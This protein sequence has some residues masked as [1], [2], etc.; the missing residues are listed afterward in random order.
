MSFDE[1]AYRKHTFLKLL[2][3]HPVL[4]QLHMSV[5]VEL[6]YFVTTALYSTV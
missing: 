4:E 2:N 6:P 1:Q 5:H 3:K